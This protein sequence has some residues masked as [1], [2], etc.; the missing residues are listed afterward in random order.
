MSRTRVLNNEE[1]KYFR[2]ANNE[3]YSNLIKALELLEESRSLLKHLD[4]HTLEQFAIDDRI[5]RGVVGV[6]MAMIRSE[7]FAEEIESGKVT[8]EGFY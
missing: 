4:F 1:Q 3:I 7:E 8:T 6:K 2:Q 5:S